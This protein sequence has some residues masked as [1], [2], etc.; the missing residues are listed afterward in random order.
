MSN[1][2]ER[3]CTLLGKY[4]N[5]GIIGLD[6]FLVMSKFIK[7]NCITNFEKFKIVAHNIETNNGIKKEDQD[8]LIKLRKKIF[9]YY[10]DILG[11]N[12]TNMVKFIN[13][14]QSYNDNMIKFTDDQCEGIQSVLNFMRDDKQ[15][16]FAIFGFAGT[17][18]TTLITKIISYMINIGYISSTTLSAP[19]NKA[20]NVIK[21]K[22]RI[23]LDHLFQ[24][25]FTKQ[26][27]N[28]S[29][30]N[31]LEKLDKSKIKVEF[32]TMHKMLSY[33][34]DFSID[35]ERIF[36]KTGKKSMLDKSNL[37]VIDECSMVPIKMVHDIIEESS[38]LNRLGIMTKILF[39][40]DPA[41]LPPV[42]E[43][44][45]SIFARKDEDFDFEEFKKAIGGQDD[46]FTRKKF[47]NFKE[48]IM[49][50]N[51]ITMKKVMRSNSNNV[52]GL[53]C[54][55][56][57][58]I[59]GDVLYPKLFKYR[60]DKVFIYKNTGKK[61]ESEWFRTATQYLNNGESNTIM[62]AWTNR[63][64]AEY[65]NEVRKVIHGKSKLEKFEVGD[66]LVLADFHNIKEFDREHRF[67]TSEQIKVVGVERVNR[68]VR[69]L[70]EVLTTKVHI[71]V[72]D[73]YTK[74]IKYINKTVK[75]YYDA[76]KL[77]AHRVG[78]SE[79]NHRE[80]FHLHVLTDEAKEILANDIK[81][82]VQKIKSLRLYYYGNHRN[83]IKTI[84]KN[85]IKP[86]WKE[87]HDKFIACF[88]D[89]NYGAALTVHNS[90]ASTFFNVFLDTDDILRNPNIDEGKHCLYTGIS[91]TANEIHLYI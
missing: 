31:L 16:M 23:D 88:A 4:N 80:T 33:S 13:D 87:F 48:K 36:T 61:V 39:L 30:T 25:K 15:N 24:K 53:C 81:I 52:I 65:N 49:N 86:L 76:W 67:Y 37:I 82:V 90:Q 56:R 72:A 47:K 5:Q 20:V 14:I 2:I 50:L 66:I 40:G 35:G 28:L 43:R 9:G 7:K 51:S 71:D 44:I 91:R 3:Y 11:E 83:T 8:K 32:S 6:D 34:N 1:V 41:Q 74:A 70:D 29:F 64:V 46:E 84:D 21:S 26:Y 79:R 55:I 19:T 57:D 75:R 45:S 38:Q 77:E 59:F 60:G 69:E 62:L 17:G 58:W 18:K 63:Q 89:V 10:Y 54:E 68:C 42:N 78:D 22:F 12:G 85:V 73:K 27:H